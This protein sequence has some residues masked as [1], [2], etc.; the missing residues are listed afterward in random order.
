MKLK[1]FSL[2]VAMVFSLA[3]FSA[4]A[5]LKIAVVNATRAIFE[6]E[7][8]K[9]AFA[10]IEKDLLPEQQELQDL[11]QEIQALNE[12]FTKDAS[13]MSAAESRELRKQIDDKNDEFQY[14]GQRWDKNLQDR[15][16]QVL[17]RLSPKFQAVLQDLVELE[18]YD[19]VLNQDQRIFLYVNPKHDVTRRMTE[20]LNNL[21][22]E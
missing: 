9:S 2:F 10:E 16:A 18:G 11:Q 15:Q 13:V 6:S 1:H 21:S 20:M 17:E 3:A 5:E 12:R 8:A 19:L 22:E 14:R 7:E 4:S